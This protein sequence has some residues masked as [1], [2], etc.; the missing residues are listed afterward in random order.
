LYVVVK[1]FFRFIILWKN[2]TTE[3]T[4]VKKVTSTFAVHVLDRIAAALEIDTSELFITS[5]SPQAELMK[6]HKAILANLNQAIADA[7]DK[8]ITD[9]CPAKKKPK[10]RDTV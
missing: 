2:L 8:A 7:V 5:A 9:Q 10:K 4:E 3:D 6:L 1:P